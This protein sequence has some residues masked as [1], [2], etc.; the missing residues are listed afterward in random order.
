MASHGRKLHNIQI[1]TKMAALTM[2]WNSQKLVVCRNSR[3]TKYSNVNW[4]F[5]MNFSFSFQKTSLITKL[6]KLLFIVGKLCF[7]K[8]LPVVIN[9]LQVQQSS[10]YWLW[11]IEHSFNWTQK[12]LSHSRYFRDTL[13]FYK[14]LFHGRSK[15]YTEH[16]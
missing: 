16:N 12:L 11:I 10:W 2:N 7:K 13:S 8:L 6:K 15:Q 3:T 5:Y 4:Q 1:P 9:I 14:L